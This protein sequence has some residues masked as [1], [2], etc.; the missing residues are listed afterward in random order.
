MLKYKFD[1]YK[2]RLKNPKFILNYL[3][4][5]FNINYQFTNLS[6]INLYVN[7]V[8]NGKCLFCDVGQA[9]MGLR[10]NER[11]ID[12]LRKSK[13]KF[14]SLELLDKILNDDYVKKKKP[15]FTLLMTEPLLS[16]NIFDII[17]HIKEKDFMVSLTT[18][19]FLL[20]Q[21]AEGL[22]KA[23]LD[24]IQVSIDGPSAIHNKIRGGEQ[25]FENAIKG[26]KILN[27]LSKMPIY[28]NYTVSN[29]NYDRIEEFVEEITAE[30]IKVRRLKIQFLDFISEEMKQKQNKNFKIKQTTSSLSEIIDPEKVNPKILKRE[31]ENVKNKVDINPHIDSIDII[32]NISSEAEIAKYF[33][34][35]GTALKRHNK[36]YFPFNLIAIKTDGDVLFHIRCFNYK[37]GNVK[38]K[39]IE[40]IFFSESAEYFRKMFLKANLCFPAC[41]RCCGMTQGI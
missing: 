34:K 17:R 9:N 28:I 6:H 38:N 7:T 29:L 8:C 20:P 15:S 10:N 32:P 3:L 1:Q 24:K 13:E 11:G 21:K 41:T 35:K 37:I 14:L 27:N 22:V 12:S 16:P 39:N 2:Y 40:E 19:G 30:G 23:G 36:C 25:F 5:R 26:I 31:L 33:S 18:N 4:Y